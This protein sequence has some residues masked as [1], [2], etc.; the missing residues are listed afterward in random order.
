MKMEEKQDPAILAAA[1]IAA[2]ILA[3]V[4]SKTAKNIRSHAEK[5]DKAE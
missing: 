1:L 4:F 3:F 5:E 2:L